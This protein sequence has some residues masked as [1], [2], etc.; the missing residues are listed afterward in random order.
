MTLSREKAKHINSRFKSYAALENISLFRKMKTHYL[1]RV[2]T[3]EKIHGTQQTAD[4]LFTNESAY[5]NRA[6]GYRS[7]SCIQTNSLQRMTGRVTHTSVGFP[8]LSTSGLAVK[9]SNAIV[10]HDVT[11]MISVSSL[12]SPS[13]PPPS[14]PPCDSSRDV[15]RQP[16]RQPRRQVSR[17]PR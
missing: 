3:A 1:H 14:C 11:E 12:L 4:K 15:C 5:Q 8:S 13:P 7:T 9:G 16:R 2:T 17:E 6:Q 10:R